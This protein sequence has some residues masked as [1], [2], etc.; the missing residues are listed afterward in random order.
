MTDFRGII[1]ED[2]ELL[3]KK[4]Q[5]QRNV[6]K[7]RAYDKVIKELRAFE[8]PIHTIKDIETIS[9]I[10]DRIKAKIQEI[11]D[12]GKL[13]AAEE[14]K[15]DSGINAI[16]IIIKI[17]GIGPVKA[18]DL[19]KNHSIRSIADLRA[20]VEKT[21]KLLNDKQLIGLKYFE[22]IQERIPRAE[23]LL[24]EKDILKTVDTVSINEN[25]K[26]ALKFTAAIVGSFRRE[27]PTSGDIDVLIGYPEGI[28]EKVAEQKFKDLIEKFEA[29][30]YITDILAKGPK[31]CMAIVKLN[32]S[33]EHSKARRLDL[34]LT[35]PEEFPYALLYFTGS[36]KF[37]IQVRKKAIEKG[38]SLSEHGLKMT[39]KDIPKPA[40]M[41][42]EEDI[43]EFLGVPFIPPNQ[44]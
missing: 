33:G 39:K 4:E 12:T 25:D 5:Q 34:L 42:N 44:R 24:H 11:I 15:K 29:K 8:K 9:G 13:K 38:Y 2:L 41:K 27:M 37:N 43:L 17:H 3:R 26:E 1:I 36:D 19:I 16:D 6:F 32:S 22:D 10:G 31:K 18:N 35:P 14:V 21:P 40:K 20:A 30:G 7:V 23:M 28:S